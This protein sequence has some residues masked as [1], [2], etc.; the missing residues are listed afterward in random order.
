M[1]TTENPIRTLTR[2]DLTEFLDRVE[3]ARFDGATA[4]YQLPHIS[5]PRHVIEHYNKAN[6]K[7]FDECGYFIFKD[8]IVF[9]DGK[10]KPIEMTMIP[11]MA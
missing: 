8:V 6:I 9:E 1:P 3:Q 11:L 4:G 10:V 5:A 7:G 2:Q